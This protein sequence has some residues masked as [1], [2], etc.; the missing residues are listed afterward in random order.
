MSGPPAFARTDALDRRAIRLD[1]NERVEGNGLRY[2]AHANAAHRIVVAGHERGALAVDLDAGAVTILLVDDP[3]ARHRTDERSG[4]AA[5]Q[6]G[7]HLR[8]VLRIARGNRH[9][10]NHW[11]TLR[12]SSRD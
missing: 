5:E 12:F 2:I 7:Q 6:L 1:G 3:R 10:V 4:V 8:D 11:S 9:V